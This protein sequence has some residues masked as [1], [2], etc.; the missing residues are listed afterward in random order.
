MLWVVLWAVAVVACVVFFFWGHMRWFLL[1]I[2]G[3]IAV[4]ASAFLQQALIDHRGYRHFVEAASNIGWWTLVFAVSV[5]VA[6]LAA[7]IVYTIRHGQS[8]NLKGKAVTENRP[9]SAMSMGIPRPMGWSKRKILGSKSEFITMDSLVDGSATFGARMMVVGINTAI[10]SFFLVFVGAGLILMKD[11]LILF[12]FPVIP[13]IWLYNIM[14]NDWQ[15][16]QK[17]KKSVAARHRGANRTSPT[18][19]SPSGHDEPASSQAHDR[20]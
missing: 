5:L 2:L 20:P 8:N 17:A 3:L 13:G 6:D 1:W 18:S 11:F 12:L 19:L 10:V 4:I 16:Y 14:H 15:E 9:L 7:M